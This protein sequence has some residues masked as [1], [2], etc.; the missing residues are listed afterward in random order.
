[1][2]NTAITKCTVHHENKVKVK[3]NINIKVGYINL[4]IQASKMMDKE[5][6]LYIVCPQGIGVHY[7]TKRII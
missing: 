4:K 5:T 2:A 7:I 6:D 3:I 1:M